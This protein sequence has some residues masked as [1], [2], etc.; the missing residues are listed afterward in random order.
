MLH[1]R[2]RAIVNHEQVDGELQVGDL[3]VVVLEV[4]TVASEAGMGM[5]DHIISPCCRETTR[6]PAVVWVI[7]SVELWPPMPL[8]WP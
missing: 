4:D 5:R 3:A 7:R 8:T 1:G 2:H 6:Q